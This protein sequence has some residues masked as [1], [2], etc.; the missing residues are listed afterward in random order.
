V[1]DDAD[2]DARERIEG[3]GYRVA[4]TDTLMTDDAAAERVARTALSLVP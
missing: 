3:M 4:V 2:A 1:I